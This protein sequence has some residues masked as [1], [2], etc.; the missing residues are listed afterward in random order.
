[1]QKR[2]KAFFRHRPNNKHQN[3]FFLKDK[4]R[5]QATITAE[6]MPS[7]KEMYNVN[8]ITRTLDFYP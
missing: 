1:M 4:S 6:R 2:Q 7:W 3:Y 5:L 8:Q